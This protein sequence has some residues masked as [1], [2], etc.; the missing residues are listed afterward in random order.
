VIDTEDD[1]L[2][3][4][5]SSLFGEDV[6]EEVAENIMKRIEEEYGEIPFIVNFLRRKP[7]VLVSRAIK[8]I[9]VKKYMKSIP[10]KF[11]ELMSISAA[12]ALGCE[13]CT[14]LHVRS[15][16]RAGASEDEVFSAIMVASQ[17]AESSRLA[18]GFRKLER[19]R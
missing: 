19:N 4:R 13:Y 8:N 17:I 16:L 7:E 14:D 11:V 15:A 1:A 6:V 5:L 18:L 10:Q 3:E 9:Q 2:K 12:V